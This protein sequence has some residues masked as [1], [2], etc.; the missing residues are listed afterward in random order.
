MILK[1]IQ[2]YDESNIFSFNFRAIKVVR[3]VILFFIVIGSLLINVMTYLIANYYEPDPCETTWSYFINEINLTVE[4]LKRLNG[5]YVF[6]YI[7]SAE[8][9]WKILKETFKCGRCFKV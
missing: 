4:F 3:N 1:F 9:Q 6:F 7:F 2:V 5:L 8:Y